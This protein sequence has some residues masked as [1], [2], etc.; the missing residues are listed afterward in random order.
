MINGDR[1][2][3]CRHGGRGQAQL[4]AE[5]PPNTET[6]FPRQCDLFDPL[7]GLQVVLPHDR[8]HGTGA[9]IGQN[10]TLCWARCGADRGHLPA[11][12]ASLIANAIHEFGTPTVPI[13]LR[14]SVFTTEEEV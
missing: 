2:P 7:I 10:R 1:P 11:A 6:L 5:C 12:E 13:A 14:H 3:C 4:F 9:F 8:Q